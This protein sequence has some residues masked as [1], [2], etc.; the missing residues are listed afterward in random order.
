MQQGAGKGK[1]PQRWWYALAQPL[2]DRRILGWTLGLLLAACAVGTVAVAVL[3]WTSSMT[4]DQRIA[5]TAATFTVGA[6]TLAVV[7]AAVALLAYGL[8]LQRPKLL[9]HIAT[10]DFEEGAINVGLDRPD[11]AGERHV[12]R[13]P[14]YRRVPG[15]VRVR[16]SVEN[17]SEWS[18]RNVAVR[19][20]FKGVRNFKHPL[21]WTVAGL[22]STTSEVI[23]VQW[24]GGAD[25]AVHGQ[26]TRDLPILDLDAAV[27]EAPGDDCA[28]SVD[29]VAEGFHQAW[30]YPIRWQTQADTDGKAGG[31]ISGYAGYPSS[32]VPP[33]RIYAVP[34]QGK[35][36]P[37]LVE[38]TLGYGYRWFWFDDL[39][40]GLYHVLAYREGYKVRGAYTVG[41]RENKVGPTI[42]HTLVAVDVHKGEVADG[43][44]LTDWYYDKFPPPPLRAMTR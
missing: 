15:A 30:T 34:V 8:A 31:S 7:A 21:E 26:W 23:G 24:E 37:W 17:T 12:R 19:V 38:S 4:L 29:V 36:L 28:M 33:I 35:Q 11:D 1:S 25:Y 44:R 14:G 42:D 9:I 13:L 32:G 27:L 20:D 6:F 16:I 3:V 41:S 18:A 39:E 5:G 10:D 40:P 2:R 22:H 43:V